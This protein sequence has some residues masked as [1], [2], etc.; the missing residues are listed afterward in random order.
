MKYVIVFLVLYLHWILWSGKFDVFHLSLGVISCA[1]VTFMS[2]NLYI[3]SEKLSPRIIKESFRFIKYVPW[4]LYQIILSNIHVASLVLS[5]GMP[6]DPKIIRY[7]TKLK[8]EL[9]LVTFANSITL[10]PGTITA[11][12]VDGEYYVHALSKKVADDL[13][14]G[15]MEDKVAQI[16]EED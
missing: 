9:S 5:P 15:E 3:Q 12:I 4:L 7:K 8:S 6:I 2:H 10:T 11:D 16:F 1:L 13:M 14:A